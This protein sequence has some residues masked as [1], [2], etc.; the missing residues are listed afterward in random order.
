MDSDAPTLARDVTNA[1]IGMNLFAMREIIDQLI[2]IR[3]REFGSLLD[4]EEGELMTLRQSLEWLLSDIR[5]SRVKQ[6]RTLKVVS[7]G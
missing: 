6:S 5:E 3:T 4:G 1:A 2:A 7:N